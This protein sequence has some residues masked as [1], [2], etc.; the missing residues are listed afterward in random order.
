MFCFCFFFLVSLCPIDNMHKQ[1]QFLDVFQE[2]WAR[3]QQEMPVKALA[4]STSAVVTANNSWEASENNIA[5]SDNR[6]L[7]SIYHF[8]SWNNQQINGPR[9]IQL[10]LQ[11]FLAYFITLLKFLFINVFHKRSICVDYYTFNLMDTGN[12]ILCCYSV[13]KTLSAH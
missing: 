11:L 5:L 13:Y 12:F 8:N 6:I 1:R 9:V 4:D 7:I 10:I 3:I 2:H